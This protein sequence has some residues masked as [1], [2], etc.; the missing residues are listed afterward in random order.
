MTLPDMKRLEGLSWKPMW[1][2]HLG[3]LQGC[4]AYLGIEPSDP[5]FFGGTGHAFVINIS[6]DVC[7]SGPTAW[8]TMMLHRLGENLGYSVERVFGQ[9]NQPGFE[10]KREAARGL[11][12][13]SIDGGYP[14]YGWELE[15]PEFYTINGYDDRGCYYSG[16][17]C[18]EGRGPKPWDEFGMSDIGIM[19][20]Y[21]VKP[22]EPADDRETVKQALA[23]ALEYSE[24][25]EKWVF[26]N[27]RAGPRG[28]DNWIRAL[29]SGKA[30]IFGVAYNAAVW[31]ECRDHAVRFLEEAGERLGGPRSLFD[32]AVG[33]YSKVA[34]SLNRVS[35]LFPFTGPRAEGVE[36]KQANIGEAVH[37]LQEAR[38]YEMSGLNSLSTILEELIE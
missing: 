24:S 18:D 19:E 16:P 31:S 4:L 21:S 13:R 35:E 5:W 38:A 27:Y 30:S 36:V 1:V 33:R 7:P 28:Y 20:V 6:E 32:E 15:Q 37:C 23:F 34:L 11:V 9:K 10:E 12:E 22:G 26:T 2:T 29:E 25:P 17:L 14:C 3:C 8:N